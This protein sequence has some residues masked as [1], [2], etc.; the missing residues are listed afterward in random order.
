MP[1]LWRY[2]VTAYETGH[3]NRNFV[4][5]DLDRALCYLLA[6]GKNGDEVVLMGVQFDDCTPAHPKQMLHRHDRSAQNERDFDYDTRDS[7]NH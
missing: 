5:I 1:G 7:G 3:E 2:S 4:A 6:V